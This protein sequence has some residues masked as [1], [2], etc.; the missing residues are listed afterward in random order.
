MIMTPEKRLLNTIKGKPTDRI[1]VYTQIPFGVTAQGFKPAPFHGYDDYDNW[2]ELDPEYQKLVGKMERECDNFFIWRP[3]CMQHD[4]F[5]VPPAMT[6]TLEPVEKDGRIV[7]TTLLETPKGQLT[8][9]AAVQPGTG[10]TW[11]LE[12]F[13]KT[14]ADAEML[15]DLPYERDNAG[16]EDYFEIKAMLGDKGVVWVT[17]PSTLMIVYQLFDPM[18]FMVYIRTDEKLIYRMMD[19]G[20]ERLRSNLDQILKGGAGP[21]IRFGGAEYA[22]PPMLSPDDFD[23]LIFRYDK[24]LMD[25]CKQYN[26]FVAV[27]CHGQIKHALKRFVEMG[28]DQ[29]DPFETV[30]DGNLT[31]QEAREIAGDKITLTGNIQMRE[32]HAAGP[33]HIESRVKEIIEQTGPGN[34]ILS[35]TGTPLEKMTSELARNYNT[36]IDAALKYG[37]IG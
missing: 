29:T 22:T 27:H 6:R 28:V 32:L 21:I 26:C 33:K 9:V 20:V 31:L 30:P 3:Q 34:L 19:V 1:P 2:R 8:S 36:F 13:C 17:V 16:V 12:H 15:L 14:P 18:N 25:L 10:H 37:Q 5:F 7:T 23:R 4:N 11:Q 24:P 35:T